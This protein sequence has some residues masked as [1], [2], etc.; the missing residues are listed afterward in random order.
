MKLFYIIQL[1]VLL[2]LNSFNLS[3]Q[4]NILLIIA[5]DVGV[6]PVPNYMPNAE[7]ANM[8]HLEALMEEGLT[9]ENVWANPVC[10]PTRATILTGRY[11][12]RTNVLNPQNLSDLSLDETSLHSYLD[13][14]T[15]SNYKSSLIGKWHLGGSVD[16]VP[17]YPNLLGIEHY[18]GL[19]RGVTNDYYNWDLTI[20]GQ[21]SNSTEYI[22]T[23]F[24][25]LAIDWINEQN[26]PW[27]CWLAYNAPH[28]PFHLPPQEMHSQGNLPTDQASI[29]ANPF[30]Y[31]LAMLESVDYEMGRLFDNIPPDVLNN[32]VIIFLGDNGTD[33]KVIQQPYPM[34]H[35]KVSLYQ[36]G[37]H[38]PMVVSGVGVN[39]TG[40]RES[41]LVNTTDLFATIVELTGTNL[42]QIH[43]SY[44][45]KHLLEEAGD[46]LRD[47]AYAE[48]QTSGSLPNGWT[49]R[50]A[51]YKLIEF[52]SGI[53]EL[54]NLLDDP[55]ETNNLLP[56]PLN[57]TA[58]AAFDKLKTVRETLSTPVSEPQEQYTALKIYPNP[59]EKD[60]FVE[61]K[62]LSP[63]NYSIYDILGKKVKTGILNN[64]QNKIEV[65][66]LNKGKYVLT[67]KTYSNPF[68]KM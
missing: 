35:G 40:E 27:F 52:E 61:W 39:R 12:F 7:K 47:C 68:V 43:D 15:N 36:G 66:D 28:T 56:G 14:A 16:V 31:F 41:A 42:T 3:A 6:E 48:V 58:Q 26:Q 24:T 25:D 11:G 55:Y 17:E 13:Q 1:L 49:A 9:F 33:R 44:S 8:P 19:L 51:E 4:P 21:N 10:S 5:D 60:L 37:I 57:A 46:G 59:V 2:I 62:E 65:I 30:P 29:D 50:D 32:T 54:Y 23:K 38:V 22:T 67:V 64:G 34:N 63:Q 20:N 18:A 53:Q 45:F